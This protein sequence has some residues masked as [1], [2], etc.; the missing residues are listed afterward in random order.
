MLRLKI[1][2]DGVTASLVD[3]K[4]IAK[5]DGEIRPVPGAADLVEAGQSGDPIGCALYFYGTVV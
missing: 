2:G 5:A 1:N 3:E 4:G